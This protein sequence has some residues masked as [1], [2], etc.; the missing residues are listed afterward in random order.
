M[1][2]LYR[3]LVDLPGAPS[4][5]KPIR[6]YMRTQLEPHVEEIIE[7]RLGSIFGVIN[8]DFDGPKVM[9]AGHM[10]EV[11]GIVTGINK[12][13]L[14]KMTNLGGMHGNVFLSQ[15]VDIIT[16]DLE[17]IPGVTASKPPHLLRGTD[18][19]PTDIKFNDLLVDIGANNDDHAKELGVRVGQQ[20]VAR[21]HYTVS[22]DGEKIFSKAW[23]DRFGCGMALEIARDT[24]K[25][26]LKCQLYTGATVQEE[27]GLRGAKTAAGLIKPDVF[28]AIDCSPCADSFDGDDVSGKI[29]EGFLLRFYDPSAIMHQG[30]K[31]FIINAAEE[32][33]IKYQYYKSMGGTDAARVQLANGGTL[34]ATIGMPARYI[35]STTSMISTKDYQEVKKIVYKI[36]RMFDA[37]TVD[38]IKQNV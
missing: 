36:I 19:K 5:E 3:D 29:G 12:N 21:N 33:G 30:M 17:K 23:D 11:G 10:D 31:Q 27:V 24:K 22:K 16:D 34:V 13:G 4:F 15:H 20:V 38:Q 28:I 9:I 25:E 14:I 1:D 32:D 7:G 18:E 26:D 6:D 2:K 35:H 37:K 8:K